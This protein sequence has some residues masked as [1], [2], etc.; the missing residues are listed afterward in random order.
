MSSGPGVV[1][2]PT[3]GPDVRRF[4]TEVGLE[5]VAFDGAPEPYGVGLN[6][7]V[8]PALPKRTLPPQLFS[9]E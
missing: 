3:G 8:R 7:M 4:F 5:E 9:F 6:R 1:P 2:N